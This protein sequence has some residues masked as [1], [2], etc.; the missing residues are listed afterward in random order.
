MRKTC[1][2]SSA[3][4]SAPPVRLRRRVVPLLASLLAVGA[5]WAGAAQAVP[6]DLDASFGTGGLITRDILP[7]NAPF[8]IEPSEIVRLGGGGAVVSGATGDNDIFVARLLTD[9]TLDPAFGGV[10]TYDITP[11]ST[12]EVGGMAV[13]AAGRVV[14]AGR[15][16]S[17]AFIMRLTPD[18][19]LDPTFATGGKRIDTDPGGFTSWG[20]MA[21]DS[22]GGIFVVNSGNYPSKIARMLPSGALDTSFG[23]N[24][25]GTTAFELNE[26]SLALDANR[27]P[28]IAGTRPSGTD[29][30]VYRVQ[31]MT[32]ALPGYFDGGFSGDGWVDVPAPTGGVIDLE[33]DGF[34]RP[35]LLGALGSPTDGYRLIRLTGAGALDASFDTDGVLDDPVAGGTNDRPSDLD[36]ENSTM[37]VAGRRGAG[38]GFVSS[39]SG[40]GGLDAAYGVGGLLTITC[41]PAAAPIG[42]GITDL[43]LDSSGAGMYAARLVAPSDPP[44]A[45]VGAILANGAIVPG[46]GGGD[47]IVTVALSRPWGSTVIDSA[48]GADGS[49]YTLGYSGRYNAERTYITKQLTNGALDPSFGGAGTI[50]ID[51]APGAEW[52]TGLAVTPAGG[53]YVSGFDGSGLR[54]R[55]AIWKFTASG[56]DTTSGF[57]VNGTAVYT[58]AGTGWIASEA[59]TIDAAGRLVIAGS[60]IVPGPP[61]TRRT[62]IAR[63]DP[64]SGALDAGFNGG[65]PRYFDLPGAENETLRSLHTL[66]DGSVVAAGSG[67]SVA[68][69]VKTTPDGQPAADFGGAGIRSYPELG[70]VV[71]GASVMITP[72]GSGFYLSSTV[73]GGG[74]SRFIRTTRLTGSGAI[75]TG[76][77]TSGLQTIGAPGQAY[78]LRR[79]RTDAAGR[80]LLVGS[81]DAGTTT[82][83]TIAR[84]LPTGAPDPG[85]AGGGIAVRDLSL[86]STRDELVSV[87]ER[88]GRIVALGAVLE[89]VSLQ[90][91]LLTVVMAGD[92][93]PSVPPTTPPVAP[94]VS[95]RITSPR[96][97]ARIARAKLRTISGRVSVTGSTVRRVQ[98]SVRRIDA[99]RCRY[100]RSAAG[101]FTATRPVKRKCPKPV[102]VTVSGGTS[103]KLAL[104]AKLP[105]G[106]YEIRS[107][108]V[109]ANGTIEAKFALRRNAIT[110]TLR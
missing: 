9:G 86:G 98:I 49:V 42:C 93:P 78:D 48:L 70:T 38:P 52:V 84:L 18:G 20:D 65:S 17:T 104:R 8:Q 33:V 61:E 107:R 75:D 103:W 11:G 19:N 12:D 6:G 66:P 2:P 82:D 26:P 47:G 71:P 101:V 7:G 14:I 25:V 56:L 29:V 45:Q 90:N 37:Y 62:W 97:G 68:A 13:D 67:A 87:F 100:L 110:L 88:G 83:S 79:S 30:T 80:L 108:A 1:G 10:R 99:R 36:V 54:P 27:R 105:A 74:G 24:G 23:I 81:R 28:V 35:V 92:P 59:I 32:D 69:A 102:W 22:D 4:R 109:L 55:A 15:A 106:R 85:F 44:A 31:G 94:T 50:V 51:T 72:S 39:R 63:V 43:D 3:T 34:G 60:E 73:D 57:G 96:H 89:P 40:A 5:G 21:L 64:A 41:D 91:R 53:I 76:F 58:F 95:S 46:F 77:G 16:E